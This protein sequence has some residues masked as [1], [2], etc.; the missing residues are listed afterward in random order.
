MIPR[1]LPP[2]P[3]KQGVPEPFPLEGVHLDLTGNPSPGTAGNRNP[4]IQP[5]TGVSPRG[6]L[7]PAVLNRP[8][9][10]MPETGG[11]ARDGAGTGC[12][13][14]RLKEWGFRSG[15]LF[16]G[17]SASYGEIV[18]TAENEVVQGG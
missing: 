4:P 11:S 8:P 9:E 2:E 18:R 12:S 10:G 7:I 13:G 15:F 16:S 1:I 17:G 6:G 5:E 14:V 3:K